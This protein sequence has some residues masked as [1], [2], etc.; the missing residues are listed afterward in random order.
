MV[1]VSEM[2]LTASVQ[3]GPLSGGLSPSG[4]RP[5]AFHVYW[6]QP[7]VGQGRGPG[8]GATVGSQGCFPSRALS[9]A[10]TTILR[11][12]GPLGPLGEQASR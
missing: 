9:R 3:K 1:A 7:Q 4:P 10:E 6:V 11:P 5:P 8:S 2:R 12:L